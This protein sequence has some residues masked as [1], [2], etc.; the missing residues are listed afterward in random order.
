MSW[1][2]GPW[3][4]GGH[5]GELSAHLPK[6]PIH[7]T[8]Q[9]YDQVMLR[10]RLLSSPLELLE[11]QNAER[12]RQ[13]LQVMIGQS[14]PLGSWAGKIELE[15]RRHIPTS[16]YDVFVQRRANRD[17][18]MARITRGKDLVAEVDVPNMLLRF[19]NRGEWRTRLCLDLSRDIEARK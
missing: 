6:G 16:A 15:I 19:P 10:Q 14:Y 13:Q 5:L 12:R 2:D 17:A 8:Q 4:I 3:G 7:I 1:G 11:F 9:G 18:H